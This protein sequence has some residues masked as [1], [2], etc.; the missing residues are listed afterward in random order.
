MQSMFTRRQTKMNLQA[1]AMTRAAQI[2]TN[3]IKTKWR[4]E[5]RKLSD[6]RTS[7][8]RKAI[9]DYIRDNPQIVERAAKEVASWRGAKFTSGA[10]K[11]SR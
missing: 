4:D 7:D 1:D 11:R 3:A 8:H 10:Q 9:G 6:F 5:G 2:A